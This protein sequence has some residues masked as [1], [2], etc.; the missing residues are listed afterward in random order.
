M[1]MEPTPRLQTHTEKVESAH[2]GIE[3]RKMTDLGPD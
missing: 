1:I 2:D 3:D